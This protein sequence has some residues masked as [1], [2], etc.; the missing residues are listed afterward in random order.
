[1][2]VI[3][4]GNNTFM[5]IIENREEKAYISKQRDQQ[6]MWIPLFLASGLPCAYMQTK[7]YQ[8]QLCEDQHIETELQVF[9][10]NR[11]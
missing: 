9:L 2:K 7:T 1:M 8:V 6:H 10:V 5:A 3:R 4:H 11:F